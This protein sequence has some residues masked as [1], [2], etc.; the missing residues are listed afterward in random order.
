MY[1]IWNVNTLIL[2]S[3]NCNFIFITKIIYSNDNKITRQR[4]QYCHYISIWRHLSASTLHQRLSS[5]DCI[6]SAFYSGFSLHSRYTQ[7]TVY[8]GSVHN[9]YA[10]RNWIQHAYMDHGMYLSPMVLPAS[11]KPKR[12]KQRDTQTLCC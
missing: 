7:S 4:L 10:N 6:S 8:S 9:A 5:N 12:D 3:W 11:G 2:S 1:T